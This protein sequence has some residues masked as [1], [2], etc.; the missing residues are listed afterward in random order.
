MASTPSLRYYAPARRGEPSA[1]FGAPSTFLADRWWLSFL[2]HDGAVQ[3]ILFVKPFCWSALVLRP[4]TAKYG[5][6]EP[7]FGEFLVVYLL[8]FRLLHFRGSS[9]RGNL[10]LAKKHGHF[11][12]LG[13]KNV[14][15]QS[16][17]LAQLQF[18]TQFILTNEF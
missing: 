4:K 9:W 5:S 6:I 13:I 15:G 16:I 11:L 2:V 12:V 10:L 8:G 17:G 1:L 3:P 14:D 18:L 7:Y